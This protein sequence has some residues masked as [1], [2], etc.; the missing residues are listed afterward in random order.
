MR[1]MWEKK[2]TWTSFNDDAVSKF[3]KNI[4]P[5][6]EKYV[7][8]E[9]KEL[10]HYMRETYSLDTRGNNYFESIV[11]KTAPFIFSAR[12]TCSCS[13]NNRSDEMPIT[14]VRA[15]IPES[16]CSILALPLPTL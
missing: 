9:A 7:K 1:Y 5:F 12:K 11:F 4:I 8:T 14:R 13:G 16:A 6:G 15:R 10:L 2:F 3:V